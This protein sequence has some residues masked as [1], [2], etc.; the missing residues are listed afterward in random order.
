MYKR[1]HNHHHRRHH[2][3]D[4]YKFYEYENRQAVNSLYY[5][6]LLEGLQNDLMP[7]CKTRPFFIP[8]FYP[9]YTQIT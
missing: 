9:Y 4:H 2:C 7:D 1:H 6:E 5:K 8:N 3:C